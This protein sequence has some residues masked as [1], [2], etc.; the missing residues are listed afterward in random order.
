M[1]KR[2]T[3]T[4]ADRDY[5]VQLADNAVVVN[6]ANVAL[7]DV[8]LDA[9]SGITF[10]AADG[11][12]R[13]VLDRGT[14]ES[15]LIYRCREAAVTVQTERDRLLSQFAATARSVHHHAEIRASMPGL[16]VRLAA[17]P[18]DAVAKGDALLILEAMKMENEIR[19]T[20]DG[21]I[22]DVRVA[23]GQAVEKGDVL[24]VLD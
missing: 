7:G 4:I 22:K 14:H 17:K 24:I 12:H 19:A 23:Q 18:G 8:A 13:A 6:G 1:D 20:T 16:V 3:V 5:D 15:V 10:R 9:R 11:V 2:Y 21:V